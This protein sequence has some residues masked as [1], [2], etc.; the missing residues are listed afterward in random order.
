MHLILR[1]QGPSVRSPY[2]ILM[3]HKL[4]FCGWDVGQAQDDFLQP[5]SGDWSCSS[6]YSGNQSIW[7]R[8]M[9]WGWATDLMYWSSAHRWSTSESAY[10]WR[11]SFS[12]MCRNTM[13]GWHPRAGWSWQLIHQ[14]SSLNLTVAPPRQNDWTVASWRGNPRFS[15]LPAARSTAA[16]V[17]GDGIL[18]L[19]LSDHH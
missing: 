13:V 12:P 9:M 14:P 4:Q 8:M 19:L 17:V 18:L 7:L 3:T 5:R 11:M 2:S 10:K 16:E 15:V 6:S 1:E